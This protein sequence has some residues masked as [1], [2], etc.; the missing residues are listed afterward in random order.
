MSEKT[1]HGGARPGAGRKPDPVPKVNVQV[2]L[3]EEQRDKLKRLGWSKWLAE[4]LD[5]IRIN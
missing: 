3:T 4:R 5:N 1:R 2:R